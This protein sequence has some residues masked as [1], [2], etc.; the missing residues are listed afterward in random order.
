MAYQQK[1]KWTWLQT[2][3]L[4]VYCD[5][6]TDEK[7]AEILRKTP[8]AIRRKRQNL[9]LT[10]ENGRGI[11][12]LRDQNKV[13][14]KGSLP[15]IRKMSAEQLL[16]MVKQMDEEYH[17]KNKKSKKDDVVLPPIPNPES[18]GEIKRV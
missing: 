16:N 1:F 4:K 8:K 3:Y 17:N 13:R 11:S 2:E 5:S 6:Y 15:P 14:A 10:K 12:K 18:T 7:L 9:G